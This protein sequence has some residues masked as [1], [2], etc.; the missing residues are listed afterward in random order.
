MTILRRITFVLLALLA[1]V[2]IGQATATAAPAR[3]CYEDNTCASPN[4]PTLSRDQV[5]SIIEGMCVE[6]GGSGPA[7]RVAAQRSHDG[8]SARAE[9]DRVLGD[10][11][12]AP[13]AIR[14]WNIDIPELPAS[15]VDPSDTGELARTPVIDWP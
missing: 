13:L 7:C 9:R 8:P 15:Y 3:V 10:S 12:A 1:T 14:G 6:Q 2:A 5:S 4:H 11:E